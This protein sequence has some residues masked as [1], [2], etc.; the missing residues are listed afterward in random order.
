[1]MEDILKFKNAKA[2]TWKMWYLTICLQLIEELSEGK[3]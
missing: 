2:T 1:M 3:C